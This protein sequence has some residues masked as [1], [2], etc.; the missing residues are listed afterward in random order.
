VIRRGRARATALAVLVVLSPVTGVSVGSGPAVAQERPPARVT[1]AAIDPVVASGTAA[2]WSLVVEHDGAAP[3]TRVDVIAEVHGPLGSRSAL[4]TALAGGVVPPVLQRSIAQ[5]RTAG[6]LPPGGVVRISG[7]VPLTGAALSG[8]TNTVHPLRLQ[9]LADG[10]EVGRIDTAIVRIGAAPATRLATTLVWPLSAP[11]ARGPD[12]DVSAALDPLTV[13]GGRLDTLVAVLGS[14]A[15][16]GT[17]TPLG[18]L[19]AGIALA[20]PAHLVEDLAQRAA[21]VPD[22]VVDDLLDAPPPEVAREPPEE[23]AL[24]AALLLQ[25]LRRA[26]LALP[27][28]PLITPYGDAD[29][30]RVLA[31]GP[32]VQ[33]LAARA[34]LDGGGRYPSLVG[35]DPAPVVLLDAPVPPVALDLLP[36]RAVLLP[37]AAIEAPDLALDVPLGEPVRTLRSPTGRPVTALVGDPYLTLALGTSTRLDPGDPV[38]AAHEVVVRTAMVHLEAPGRSGRALVLLPPT[39]FDPDRRFATELVGRLAEAP[40]LAPSAAASLVAADGTGSEPARLVG[41]AP[42]PLP[43]RLVTALASTR[44]D[45][46]LLAGAIEPPEGPDEVVPVGGRPLRDASDELLRATSRAFDGDVERA[47]ALLAGVRAGVDAAFG[48]VTLAVTDVTLTDRDG[49]VPI[50]VTHAG[51]VPIRVRIEVS[52]PA[53]L[54]WTDGRVRE[55]TLGSDDARAIEVPV[56]SGATGRFPVTVRVTDPTGERVLATDVVGVRA[57]AVAGPALALIGVT[58]LLLTVVGTLRQRRRGIAWR[59]VGTDGR[60]GEEVAR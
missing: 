47:V 49:T 40:W 37:H 34:L 46:E 41:G 6:P 53:A 44:R 60:T 58:V 14:V 4:R 20:A 12:G 57:T 26:A 17:D 36:G 51:G 10:V 13:A 7:A 56:R 29:L 19:A 59:K 3:W 38:R 54:T 15:L 30:S 9:V 48:T 18:S 28:G 11:P 8:P 55:L 31:S 39:G 33:P 32:E 27:E 21:D 52:G 16:A 43:P 42:G 35:R 2:N 25:R 1:L 50:G 5:A 22:D 45:L 23:L 24:R